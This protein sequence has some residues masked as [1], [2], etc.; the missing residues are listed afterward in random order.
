MLTGIELAE[1]VDPHQGRKK[2][3]LKAA[4]KRLLTVMQQG[5]VVVRMRGLIGLYRLLELRHHWGKG[6]LVVEPMGKQMHAHTR[7]MGRD[8]DDLCASGNRLR[9]I[10]VPRAA[11]ATIQPPG[12]P[13]PVDMAQA[14]GNHDVPVGGLVEQYPTRALRL[15]LEPA[16]QQ[17]LLNLAKLSAGRKIWTQIVIESTLALG[18]WHDFILLKKCFRMKSAH[19]PLEVNV[20]FYSQ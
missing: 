3:G 4:Q 19:P 9:A 14:H 10:R 17:G 7:E 20:Q 18:E 11:R 15:F 6:L 1:T 5:Q 16:P 8:P 12:S 2:Q 13:P